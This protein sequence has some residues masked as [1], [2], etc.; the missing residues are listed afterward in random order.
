MGISGEIVH[1]FRP[2]S[3]T[4]W[5]TNLGLAAAKMAVVKTFSHAA[6]YLYL[7]K[8]AYVLFG[9]ALGLDHLFGERRAPGPWRVSLPRIAGLGIPPL[10]L[11]VF[12]LPGVSTI[13][14]PLI[15]VLPSSGSFFDIVG[16]AL[17]YVVITSFYKRTVGVA[18]IDSD[19]REEL[20]TEERQELQRLR[21]EM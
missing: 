5:G 7:V 4:H 3:S 19:K 12:N 16:T 15:G 17:S 8:G 9:L 20:T 1:P 11:T 2:K 14:A 18:E 6:R 10:I 13:S 21:R